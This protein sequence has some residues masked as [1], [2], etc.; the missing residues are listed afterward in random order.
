MITVGIPR[1][2]LY[3]QY[4]PMCKVFFEE[5]GAKVT[6]SEPTSKGVVTA[7][8]ARVVAETCL[9]VKVFCGHVMALTGKCDMVF[10]PAV[11][12]LGANAYNCSKFLGLPDLVKGVVRDCPPILDIDI[13]V[14]KGRRL[15]YEN[16]YRLGR[17]FTWNPLRVKRAAE[18]AWQTH[19]AYEEKMRREALTPLQAIEAVCQG[20]PR[21]ESDSDMEAAATIAVIGHPYVI[22]DEYINHRLISKLRSW[23][24]KV[25]T[26]EMVSGE[27]LDRAIASF[28]GKP[29]WTYEDEVTGAGGYFLKQQV[30]GVLGVVPFG[31]GPDSVMIDIL[32]RYAKREQARP[33]MPLTIDDHT[34]EAG[35]V[36]RL[37]AFVDMILRRKRHATCASSPSVTMPAETV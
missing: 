37:E 35:L 14:N 7:G 24:I 5:L 16:I 2:L 22:Y 32:Q 10:V 33:F 9:P 13:D 29:Y 34:A 26:P 20:K 31:C 3:Y 36:T 21:G 19:L 12:S 27:D 30:D 8:S 25:L 23:K 17:P 11:R 18:K 1:S 28:I 4:Y 15:L 6:V